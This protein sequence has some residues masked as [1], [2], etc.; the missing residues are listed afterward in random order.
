[1]PMPLAKLT[2]DF[3]HRTGLTRFLPARL[4]ADGAEVTPVGW[5]GSSDVPALT[6]ANAFVVVDSDRAQWQR[7]DLIRVLLK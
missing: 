1:L 5:R 2:Q 6:R 4:S 7:G 3:G